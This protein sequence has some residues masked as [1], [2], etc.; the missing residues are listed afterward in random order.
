MPGGRPPGAQQPHAHR[1]GVNNLSQKIN[2]GSL[3][4]ND[5]ITPMSRDLK[6]VRGELSRVWSIRVDLQ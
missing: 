1:A 3:V 5:V 4:T 6:K 2:T